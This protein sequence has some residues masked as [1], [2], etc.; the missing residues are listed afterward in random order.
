MYG[1]M[2][3]WHQRGASRDRLP[4]PPWRRSSSAA[5]GPS[6]SLWAHR[7]WVRPRSHHTHGS[8]TGGD[9]QMTR[10]RGTMVIWRK[11]AMI[12]GAVVHMLAGGQAGPCQSTGPPCVVLR[13]FALCSVCARSLPTACPCPSR[14]E[15]RYVPGH[16]RAVLVRS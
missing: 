2:V 16:R 11:K 14:H 8:S 15:P 5:S 12:E 1:T 6:S 7:A 9:G 13:L 4:V 3:Q 10:K